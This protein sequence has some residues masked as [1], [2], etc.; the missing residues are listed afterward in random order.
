MDVYYCRGLYMVNIWKGYGSLQ[1]VDA[2]F[3]KCKIMY[4]WFIYLHLNTKRG[5]CPLPP[6]LLCVCMC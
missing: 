6:E 5:W 3:L 2:E 1:T 4:K